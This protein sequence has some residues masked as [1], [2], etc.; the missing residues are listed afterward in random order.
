MY[1]KLSFS[2]VADFKAKDK[3]TILHVYDMH[4]HIK[5]M[6]WRERSTHYLQFL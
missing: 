6:Y 2:D 5:P 1:E 4:P 3:T